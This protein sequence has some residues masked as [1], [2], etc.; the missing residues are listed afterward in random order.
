[1]ATFTAETSVNNGD[2]ILRLTNT[3]NIVILTLKDNDSKTINL[4]PGKY[5]IEWW[6]W[7]G[8]AAE[9]TIQVDSDPSVSPLPV[10]HTYK[11]SGPFDDEKVPFSFTI[12]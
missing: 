10:N 1:M 5:W 11:Y 9:Y 12:I 2:L 3:D 6:F 8:Q 7:S 4:L